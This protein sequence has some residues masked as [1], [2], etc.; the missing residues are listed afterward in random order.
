MELDKICRLCLT[1]KKDMRNIFTENLLEMIFEF[2]NLK[3]KLRKAKLG[4]YLIEFACRLKT[5]QA[6]LRRYASSVSTK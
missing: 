1:I 4:R 6:G 2:S 5:R 3:V